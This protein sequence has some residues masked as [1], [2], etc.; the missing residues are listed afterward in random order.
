MQMNSR[1]L[2]ILKLSR[3]FKQIFRK[4][5]LVIAEELLIR[6]GNL[7]I[8]SMCCNSWSYLISTL[9]MDIG[10]ICS[11]YYL[12]LIQ[13]TSFIHVSVAL[14][15]NIYTKFKRVRRC[16]QVWCLACECYPSPQSGLTS[17][18]K[19]VECLPAD[20]GWQAGRLAMVRL[21]S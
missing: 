9:D 2:G 21:I 7:D 8:K 4:Y 5:F 17:K 12:P 13:N 16:Y 11:L 6:N 1:G 14:S 3:N 20:W 18:A 10:N 19:S 15:Q